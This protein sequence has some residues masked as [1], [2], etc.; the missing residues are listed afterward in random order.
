MSPVESIADLDAQIS[1]HGQPVTFRRGTD[2][3]VPSA[4][5]VRGYKPEQLVGLI[6]QADRTIIVSPTGLGSFVPKADDLVS[7][8]GT[9]GTVQSVE[10]VQMGS[11]PVT[12]RMNI[13][14]R[15]T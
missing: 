1:E 8:S 9:V 13:R 2:T 10:K 6:T 11:P 7:L 5:F 15:F 12:V 4:G 3:P 14:A